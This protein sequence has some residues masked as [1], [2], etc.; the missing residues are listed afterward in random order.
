MPWAGS[1][2]SS[3]PRDLVRTAIAAIAAGAA[4]GGAVVCVVLAVAHGMAR[5]ADQPFADIALGGAAAG[6]AVAASVAWFV[7]RPLGTWRAFGVAISAVAGSALVTVLT[8]P[9]DMA[10]GRAGLFALAGLCAAVLVV[11]VRMLTREAAAG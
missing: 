3:G 8:L 1:S 6:L 7:G 4:T 11:V 9:V 5:G 10:A 2:I